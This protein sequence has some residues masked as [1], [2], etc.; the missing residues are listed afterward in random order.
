LEWLMRHRHI[1]R[2]RRL[3]PGAFDDSL[4]FLGRSLM[5]YPDEAMIP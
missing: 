5:L 4:V 2:G 3:R 1:D